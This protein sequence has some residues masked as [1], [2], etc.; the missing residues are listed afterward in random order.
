MGLG[1]KEIKLREWPRKGK[2]GGGEGGGAAQGRKWTKIII[3]K[4]LY[5]YVERGGP[6]WIIVLHRA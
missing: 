3:K 5:A 2:K 4:E 6:F 1:F